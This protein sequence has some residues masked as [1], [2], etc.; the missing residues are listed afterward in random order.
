MSGVELTHPDRILYPKLK[1]TKADL[2][3]Y[4]L[5]V[6]ELLLPYVANRPLSIVRCP[7][8]QNGACFYQKHLTAGMPQAI[9]PIR[10][11]DKSGLKQYVS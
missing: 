2:A 11:R 7:D 4:Y 10:L 5:S 9:K 1:L 8:G 3:Q 6:A